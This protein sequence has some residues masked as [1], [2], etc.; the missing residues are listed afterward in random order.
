MC[1]RRAV[2]KDKNEHMEISLI[3]PMRKEKQ[4][5]HVIVSH[6]KK[7]RETNWNALSVETGQS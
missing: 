7:M 3:Q 4:Q 6:V 1:G 5:I 2:E